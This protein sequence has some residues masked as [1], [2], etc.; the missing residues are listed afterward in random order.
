MKYGTDLL[1]HTHFARI[2]G[3]GFPASSAEDPEYG[4]FFRVL[5]EMGYKGGVSMEGSPESMQSL[6]YEA[7]AAC[8]LLRSLK[9]E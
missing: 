3:R 9:E 7:E 2:Q 5:R 6:S 1:V 4:T 8:R